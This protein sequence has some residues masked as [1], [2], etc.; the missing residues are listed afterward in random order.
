MSDSLWP[1]NYSLPSSSVPGIFQERILKSVAISFSNE[2]TVLGLNTILIKCLNYKLYKNYICNQSFP[3]FLDVAYFNIEKNL[4]S[5]S[6]ICRHIFKLPQQYI[7][8][9][10]KC[11]SIK[12]KNGGIN[13]LTI[14]HSSS[15]WEDG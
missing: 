9:Y 2:C 8:F 4:F 15:I 6:I 10:Q 5:G 13:T 3:S 7:N 1:E 12:S 11:W 14:P